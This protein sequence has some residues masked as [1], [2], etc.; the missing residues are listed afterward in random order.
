M[1]AETNA[2]YTVPMLD[3]P[4]KRVSS[5]HV[6]TCVITSNKILK[7]YKKVTSIINAKKSIAAKTPIYAT[8][9]GRQVLMVTLPY[10]GEKLWTT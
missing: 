9:I 8:R 3:G 6:A 5:F 7:L 2:T 10:L 4:K 1:R